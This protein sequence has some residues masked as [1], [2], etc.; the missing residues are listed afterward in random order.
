MGKIVKNKFDNALFSL[1]SH[2]DKILFV[3]DSDLNFVAVSDSFLKEFGFKDQGELVGKSY[4]EVCNIKHPMLTQIHVNK[5][6]KQID[7]N[8]SSK[9]Y[10]IDFLDD[11]GLRFF[12]RAHIILLRDA[13]E[14]PV[15]LLSIVTDVTE[16]ELESI[17]M[18]RV[19][20][21]S[22]EYLNA[23]ESERV[24][25][26][27]ALTR[28]AAFH[29]FVDLTDNVIAEP[30][31]EDTY[32][33]I[34][35]KFPKK[36]PADYD[37]YIRDWYK[38]EAIDLDKIP[39]LSKYLLERFKEGIFYLDEDIYISKYDFFCKKNIL[40]SKNKFNGH[41]EACVIVRD[42]SEASR[43]E[44]IFHNVIRSFAKIYRNAYYIDLLED[45]FEEIQSE[46]FFT[47]N[48]RNRGL[49][50]E[51]MKRWLLM[52]PEETRKLMK[53]FLD[54]KK[55]ASAFETTDK[56]VFEYRDFDLK[57]TRS[58]FVV[59]D[60][61]ADGK[62]RN[63]LWTTQSIEDEKLAELEQ[64]NALKIANEKAM[65]ASQSKT[66]FL[67]NMSHDIRTPM[68][69]I[70][71][72]A[73]IASAHIDDK[74]KVRDCIEKI[75][76]SGRHLQGLVNDILDMSRIE[77]G[78][79]VLHESECSLI[80]VI[81]TILPIIQPLAKSKDIEFNVDLSEIENKFVW[82]D[83]LKINQIL[84]NLATN[85]IK[86][87]LEKTKV[88][89]IVQQIK[90]S[91]KGYGLYRFIVSDSG[92]GMS[93]EFLKH[94]FEPFEREST[95]TISGIQGTGLG[96]AITKNLVELMGGKI[97]VESTIGKGSTFTFELQLKLQNKKDGYVD[98]SNRLENDSS[99]SET[100]QSEI[101]KKSRIL[102]VEDNPLNRTIAEEIL[103]DEG[104][105]SDTACD[106]T[107]AI[108]ILTKSKINKYSVVLMDIQM[109]VMNGYEATK[110]I[111]NMKRPDLAE[112]PI[113]AMTA[114]AFEEDK[115]LAIECGMNGHISKPINITQLKKMLIDELLKKSE[116][117]SKSNDK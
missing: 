1:I 15:G 88:N 13:D 111:R 107:E 101:I 8:I 26:R 43:R 11:K 71:G 56:K 44:K 83:P 98:G 89:L 2:T 92:I 27:E 106:G 57:W 87:S 58:V 50:Q 3:I 62:A 33:I 18:E 68:N 82:A 16:K 40:L 65:V 47:G 84:L 48:I 63:I 31:V 53:P 61:L 14:T 29:Y 7:E 37:E 116:P 17:R 99:A 69:A 104:F 73:E 10:K 52:V 113:I 112:I 85:S 115:K 100:D 78:K 28:N 77:S 42:F 6:K 103:H 72:F 95:A 79:T 22:Q 93:K 38:G 30:A 49:A 23:L 117:S 36:F 54:V 46:D 24:M 21:F 86:Y 66:R 4:A 109:P 20:N 12:F 5:L 76:T 35:K 75:M 96:L 59:T 34:V 110:I 81:E 114:N 64:K 39:V 55:M 60:R 32:S 74:E 102:L 51:N 67:S 80:S 19:E 91:K 94:I 105:E 45:S 9:Y 108:D 41:I 25:Y 90:P 70:T 97:N